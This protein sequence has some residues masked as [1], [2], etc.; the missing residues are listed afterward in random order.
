MSLDDTP[1]LPLRLPR[2]AKGR[3]QAQ[4]AALC[5]RHSA[6]PD[7]PG[8]EICLVTTR[9]KG[10][11]TLPKG[12]PISGQTPAE[13]AATEALEEAGLSGQASDICLGVYSFTKAGD[14]TGRTCLALVFPVEV[15]T[16]HD[17]WP[18]RK[19]R[20]RKWVRPAEAARLL[21]VPE[22]RHIVLQFDKRQRLQ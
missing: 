4:F 7:H 14:K 21:K 18:E 1:Q 9:G 17:D 15:E 6:D 5:W 8:I 13:A 10:R 19:A 3:T 11:W 12:W 20:R 22:L 2:K 16:V